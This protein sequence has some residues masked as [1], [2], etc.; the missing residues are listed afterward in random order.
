VA[1]DEPEIEADCETERYLAMH[2]SL[3]EERIRAGL[4]DRST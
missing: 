1:D 4:Q 3:E 2:V